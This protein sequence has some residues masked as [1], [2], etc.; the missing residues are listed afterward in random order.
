MRVLAV[1]A[2]P[3][4]VEFLCAG[5]LAKFAQEGHQIFIAHLCNGDMGG[6]D[7]A[8]EELA[9][10]RKKEA[11]EAGKIIGA[12]VLGGYFGDL[13]L[14][15]DN[16]E[17][18]DKVV[19]LI[20]EVKPDIIITHSP[21]DYM[22]DHTHTSRIVCD[23]AFTATL[24]NY[25]TKFPAHESI[26]PIYFMDTMAGI[27]FQPTEYVDITDTFDIKKKMLLCHKS[28]Y[29]W[30]DSHH[31]T[32][33]LEMLEIMARFRGIQCGVKYAEGFQKLEVWG[34][35]RPYRLLP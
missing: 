34:R 30:L 32:Q 9:R 35:L 21:H 26:F 17:S 8:P 33:A 18:R 29:K 22:I 25:K 19:D 28:Q 7:I 24:P 4:D 27:N 20:R 2:H 16:K 14:Y 12:E 3:D 5:T 13:A 15:R 23:A 11:E 31:Q 1:G 6:R 10:I